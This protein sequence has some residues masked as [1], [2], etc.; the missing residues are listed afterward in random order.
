[1]CSDIANYEKAAIIGNAM[2]IDFNL[3]PKVLS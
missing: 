3:L 1:M 2:F